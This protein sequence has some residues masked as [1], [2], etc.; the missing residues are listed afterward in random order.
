MCG[1][2][3]VGD[4]PNAASLD[5]FRSRFGDDYFTFWVGGV[6]CLVVNTQLYKDPS[7]C[8]AAAAAQDAWLTE[9]LS[10]SPAPYT[11]VFSHIP[12][13][14]QTA[15]EPNGYFNLDQETR[16]SLL[17]RMQAGGVKAW[18]CG[19]YHRNSVGFAGTLQVIVSSAT[20]TTLQ[21]SGEDPL[22]LKGFKDPDCG[23]HTSGLR[24][25]KVHQ[26]DVVHKWYTMDGVPHTVE[27]ASKN[28]D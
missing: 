16:A 22:G 11:L 4:R 10:H 1:N 23:G 19:H 26:D 28:W 3:D 7:G 15:D 20:G 21:P 27:V 24:L 8:P 5:L 9:Q 13:F 25:V 2:H 18:F 14:I 17:S 12:P 6:R